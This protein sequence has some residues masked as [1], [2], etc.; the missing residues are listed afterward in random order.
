MPGSLVTLMVVAV[1]L[2]L[3]VIGVLTLLA[4][5]YRQV[6]QGKALIV[7]TLKA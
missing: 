4:R 1:A 3:V 2:A 5:F 6:D 7:N